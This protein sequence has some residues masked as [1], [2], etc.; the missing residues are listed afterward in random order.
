[1]YAVIETG[2]KQYKVALGEKIKVEKLSVAEGETVNFDRVL[3]V[4]EGDSAEVGTPTLDV[5]VSATVVA[6]GKAKKIRVFKMK[7]RKGYR[8]TQGHRQ[9]YTEV[10]ITQIG[11][12]KVAASEKSATIESKPVAK[13]DG[14]NLTDINGIGPV[15]E[16]KLHALGVTTFQ[17]IAD[18]TDE[19]IERVNEQLNFKGRIEREQW[20]EQAK[21]LIS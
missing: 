17:Q 12:E 15:I 14:D 2:G 7:R 16:E 11:G 13:S 20:V 9:Q 21:K 8:L 3:M 10:E 1:M 5:P 6:H 18:F 19:D 4:G